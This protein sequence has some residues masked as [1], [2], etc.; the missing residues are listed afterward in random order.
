[1]R[2]AEISRDLSNRRELVPSR[3]RALGALIAVSAA[4]WGVVAVWA[5]FVG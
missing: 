5:H 2:T 4:F 3:G 1:M